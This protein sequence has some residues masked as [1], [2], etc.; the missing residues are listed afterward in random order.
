[1]P[2]PRHRTLQRVGGSLRLV[3]PESEDSART[4]RFRFRQSAPRPCASTGSSNSP[5]GPI[6][7]PTGRTTAWS[8]RLGAALPWS[9]TISGA[10]GAT[11]ATGPGSASCAFRDL[12]H[13]CVTLLLGLGT[14]P[15]VVREIVGHSAI[16]VTMTIYAHVSLDEKRKT[17]GKRSD[18]AVAVKC[19]SRP[20]RR[21][22]SWRSWWP[23]ARW[24]M[25]VSTRP[26][27]AA[28]AA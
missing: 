23:S 27:L 6:G 28:V 8:A 24:P 7:G 11:S 14:P 21:G 3:P 19:R 16:E 10:T 2:H 12:R 1:M 17:L 5:S 25:L 15:H 13:T 18:D 22:L 20:S 9:R 26:N 4:V